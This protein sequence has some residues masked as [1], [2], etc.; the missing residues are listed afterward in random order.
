[1][2]PGCATFLPPTMATPL[3]SIRAKLAAGALPKAPPARVARGKGDGQRCSGCEEPI[4]P[5]RVRYE[6]D[7]GDGQTLR[8]HAHCER[9]WRKE[10][11]GPRPG[12]PDP[13]STAIPSSPLRPSGQQVPAIRVI[14]EKPGQAPRESG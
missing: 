5:T 4:D 8:L 2:A 14:Q 9:Y 7:F 3:A 11:A 1:M 10:I 12:P 6:L 13:R